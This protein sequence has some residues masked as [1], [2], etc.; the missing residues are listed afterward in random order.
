MDWILAQV[1][2]GILRVAFYGYPTPADEY[3]AVG[4]GAIRANLYAKFLEKVWP[5][6]RVQP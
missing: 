6:P 4:L 2:K 1:M 3:K 5:F